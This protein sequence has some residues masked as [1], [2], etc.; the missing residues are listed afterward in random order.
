MAYTVCHGSMAY[1]C[2]P[3]AYHAVTI[4]T[5]ETVVLILWQND[6]SMTSGQYEFLAAVVHITDV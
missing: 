1:H 6:V 5:M 3:W 2:M 4:R